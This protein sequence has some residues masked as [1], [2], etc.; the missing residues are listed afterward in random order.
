MNKLKEAAQS[1]L[2]SKTVAVA[3]VSSKGDVAANIIYKKLR[4]LEYEIYP[5][6]PNAIVVEGD[7][8]YPSLK[9]IPKPV[10]LVVIGTHPDVTA[11]I[12][13]EC[14]ELNIKQVWIHKSLGLGSYHEKAIQK[15]QAAGIRLIPGGCPMMFLE[16]V[17]PAHKCMKWFFRVSGKEAKPI[18]FPG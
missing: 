13:D 1:F 7:P 17:D 15:A 11:G 12:I 18:G 5:V 8:S 10:D 6:N 2:Q 3:G 16:P 4:D 9:A 14:I